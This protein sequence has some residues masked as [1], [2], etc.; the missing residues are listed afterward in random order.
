LAPAT[1]LRIGITGFSNAG[2]SGVVAGE[3]GRL[4]ARRGHEIHFIADA[5]PFRFSLYDEQLFYH[6]V[7]ASSHPTFRYPPYT[8]TLAAKMAE[9]ARRFELDILHVHYALPHAA[10]AI[11][12]QGILGN[13]GRPKLV[14]TLH[15]TDVTSSGADSAL[16]DMTRYSIRASDAVTAV[17]QFLRQAAIETFPETAEVV[18]IPN[19]VD[20]G[21]YSR[22]T[23]GEQRLKLAAEEEVLLVHLSNFRA[24]KR[25]VDTVRI[26]AAVNE[27]RSA[28]LVLIGEGPEMAAVRAEGDRLNVQ[29]RIRALGNQVH[30]QPLLACGDVFLLP[31]QEE[32]FGLAALE[33]LACG[34]PAV[35]SDV[36]GLKE[37]IENGKSGFRTAVGDTESMAARVLEMVGDRATLEAYREEACNRAKR[38]DAERIVPMY[39]ELYRRTL[40]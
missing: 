1:P 5:P 21:A 22:I 24:V 26:L 15:G 4:L 16:H 11:L 3:L 28:R 17:S 18:L 10:A 2:G 37:V 13:T 20:L 40:S 33:A 39:E 30:V 25:P 32:S 35:T 6:E 14:T 7:A 9:V 12:A 34:V 38:F 31:S 23:N 36:G 29:D 8:L 19:F 27:R